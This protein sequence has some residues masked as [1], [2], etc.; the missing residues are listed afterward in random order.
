[1][2]VNIDTVY[3]KVLAMAN[4]EQRGYITPQE[5]NL[6]ADQAQMDIFERYFHDIRES[7]G[8]MQTDTEFSNPL[9][10]L[11]EKLSVFRVNDATIYPTSTAGVITLPTDL[12]RLGE[13]YYC[14][15]DPYNAN[16][17]HIQQIEIEE[18]KKKDIGLILNMTNNPSHVSAY[19]PTYVRLTDTTIQVY[20]N[21][22]QINAGNNPNINEWS[23]LGPAQY[24][25]ALGDITT[26][27]ASDQVT[28]SSTEGTTR[29]LEYYDATG[30]MPRIIADSIASDT[31]VLTPFPN[32]NSTTIFT[33]SKPAIAAATGITA[34]FANPN[35]KCNYI[36]KP[37]TPNWAYTEIN[38]TALYNAG[39]ST[40]FE[41]HSSEE[42]YL[43]SRI[44]Q[45]AGITLKDGSLLQIGGAEEAKII[46]TQKQ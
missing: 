37:T 23:K 46:Q 15:M 38:G 4:K 35:T 40:N 14:R 9:N 22:H 31:S 41:L 28:C 24:Y 16:I 3:Q 33:I 34:Y 8:R 2:A 42:S 1:M 10:M 7:E 12:Y 11:E 6:Y 21:A 43:I 25:T 36:K 5:F 45:L 26:V 17:R 13:I 30:Y 44:T 20:P 29:I 32:A 27:L 19:R 39:N 18:I